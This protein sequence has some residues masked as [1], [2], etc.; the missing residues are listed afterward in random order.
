[1]E[2]RCMY[3]CMHVCVGMSMS[4]CQIFDKHAT[5]MPARAGGDTSAVVLCWC[6]DGG[7]G[8]HGCRVDLARAK[9]NHFSAC[10]HCCTQRNVSEVCSFERP[11]KTPQDVQIS[12][13]LANFV[14]ITIFCRAFCEARM[15][16]AYEGCWWYTVILKS[17]CYEYGNSK[18]R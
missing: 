1:M 18:K 16:A 7:R 13:H 4:N 9:T 10:G 11:H 2:Q 8:C 14:I 5:A 17:T 3:V 12:T 15:R 6:V